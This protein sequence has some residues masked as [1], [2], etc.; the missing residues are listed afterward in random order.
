MSQPTDRAARPLLLLVEDDPRLGPLI[1]EVLSEA[2]DV[3]LVPDGVEG[4]AAALH[5]PHDLIVLDRRLPGVDGRELL[6]RV[7]AAGRRTPILVLSALGSIEDRVD[8]LD[9]GA[10]DYLVKP[11]D[12]GELLARLRALRRAS[13]DAPVVL[14]IGGW[15]FYPEGRAV[16]SPRNERVVLTSKE[17][18]VLR[19]LAESPEREFTP[20]RILT[21]VFPAGDKLGVVRTNVHYI[22][23]K[24]DPNIIATVRGVGYRL[25]AL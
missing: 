18:G 3:T 2:Y 1:L 12:I 15:R 11:F 17:S 9:S 5:G 6:R 13:T 14:D 4:L 19:L 24:T 20:E 16:Y 23:A 22:R 25:G 10:N 8:G 21:A 7:R